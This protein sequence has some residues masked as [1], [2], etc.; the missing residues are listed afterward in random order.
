MKAVFICIHFSLTSF[1]ADALKL[2]QSDEKH[3]P[4]QG[5]NVEM[6]FDDKFIH[7]T[8][9]LK[10]K[11]K[12]IFL[13]HKTLTSTFKVGREGSSKCLA[14]LHIPKNAGTTIEDESQH[15]VTSTHE[16]VRHWGRFDSSLVCSK[17]HCLFNYHKFG[18][19][20]QGR[21][22]IWHVPPKMDNKL[23]NSYM[24]DGCVT[25]CVVRSPS[26]KF[27]SQLRSDAQG[28]GSC[29]EE[30]F[31]HRTLQ[32]DQQ[33]RSYPYHDDCHYVSQTE[34]IYGNSDKPQFCSRQLRFEHLKQDF[35]NLMAEFDVPVSLTLHSNKPACNVSVEETNAGKVIHDLVEKYY[36]DDLQHF[37][38]SS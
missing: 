14:F 25:F 16:S 19:D 32:K 26:K 6:L 22:S 11:H 37:G 8:Y 9:V 20:G 12:A 7:D 2:G 1:S 13:K 35:D 4:V 34:Y 23:A 21:C 10:T 29:S 3:A 36:V 33:I 28:N 15:I 5:L 17:A 27:E 24:S 18:K 31:Y 38:Y 30:Q